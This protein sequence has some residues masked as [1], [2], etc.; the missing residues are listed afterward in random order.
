MKIKLFITSKLI[1][2]IHNLPQ[3]IYIKWLGKE[4]FIEK[5]KRYWMFYPSH[6][7]TQDWQLEAYEYKSRHNSIVRHQRTIDEMENRRW[8][9]EKR[10][11][12]K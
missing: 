11:I 12:I 4:Y 10:T 3:C 7:K 5:R 8:E 2:K 6:I 9:K 1:P